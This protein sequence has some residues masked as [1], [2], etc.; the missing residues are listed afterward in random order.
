MLNITKKRFHKIKKSK[1]QSKK[2]VA[3]RRKRKKRNKKSFRRGKRKSYNLKKKSLKNQKGG[4]YTI[5]YLEYDNALQAPG[6]TIVTGQ[7]NDLGEIV[8]IEAINALGTKMA[9][10]RKGIINKLKKLE[11]FTIIV[12]FH[13]SKLTN[14]LNK[15]YKPFDNKDD[16]KPDASQLQ[17]LYKKNGVKI[18]KYKELWN[19]SAGDSDK[20]EESVINA[21]IE[22]QNDLLEKIHGDNIKKAEYK[23]GSSLRF[24][25]KFTSEDQL[26]I[27]EL[28][29]DV[30]VMDALFDIDDSKFL[31]DANEKALQR[32]LAI[33]NTSLSTFVP[34]KINITEILKNSH[35][36]IIENK[37]ATVKFATKPV[38]EQL[39]LTN[40]L[41]ASSFKKGNF[42]EIVNRKKKF[43]V[44]L[45]TE[46]FTKKDGIA[47]KG[48]WPVARSD[49]HVL[50]TKFRITEPFAKILSTKMIQQQGIVQKP[51]KGG[52]GKK[53][54]DKNKKVV[55]KPSSP[56]KKNKITES[57]S[58]SSKSSDKKKKKLDLKKVDSKPLSPG[59]NSK[60]KKTISSIE[61]LPSKEKAAILD[62]KTRVDNLAVDNGMKPLPS[63]DVG[64]N[65]K[66]P[67]S[68]SEKVSALEQVTK[69]LVTKI[70][71]TQKNQKAIRDAKK[72]AEKAK[73]LALDKKIASEAAEVIAAKKGLDQAEMKAK[74]IA[75]KI[76][77]KKAIREKEDK[78]EAERQDKIDDEL[79]KILA[80]AEII[81][82]DKEKE[83]K[84]AKILADKLKA[85]GKYD[86]DNKTGLTCSIVLSIYGIPENNWAKVQ[87]KIK[88]DFD[89]F[90]T[91]G[92][93]DDE[94][95]YLAAA[96][97]IKESLGIAIP[98][99]EKQKIVKKLSEGVS[100]GAQKILDKAEFPEEFADQR[101][102]P[103]SY[104]D[105]TSNDPPGSP[106]YKKRAASLKKKGK[107]KN[108]R[109]TV[110]LEAR[111]RLDKDGEPAAYQPDFTLE[112][113]GFHKDAQEWLRAV[114]VNVQ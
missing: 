95:F 20:F 65:V 101:G 56:G 17:W 38:L 93:G 13:D 4:G 87:G 99:E 16:G 70:D 88:K 41:K 80:F 47:I 8:E 59:K 42:Q 43:I 1:N 22:S 92:G 39:W 89:D 76:D 40:L 79:S 46:K 29:K 98:Q 6:Y 104:N 111:L 83:Q 69:D 33:L 54:D 103:P 28:L 75:E 10:S 102:A 21:V 15:V 90:S 50:Q 51:Q 26:L 44:D 113:F 74:K 25:R 84:E 55:A 105:A 27:H 14:A 82:I 19:A 35:D 23:I 81:S 49:V 71:S 31:P 94:T 64:D 66:K 30:A 36:T 57:K 110:Y 34:E 11:N 86:P 91:K 60:G 5:D 67:K 52:A 109:P 2:R 100:M 112:K 77:P 68:L 48:G 73:S 24:S 108:T 9:G 85:S 18:I 63:L 53:S 37:N 62:L 106:G 58:S 7:Q 107:M 96:N 32:Q 78:I 72:A 45:R 3:K 97:T 114:N 12:H 61:E